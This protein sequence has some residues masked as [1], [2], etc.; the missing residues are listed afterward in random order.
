M[1]ASAATAVH[2]IPS[3][4]G[5]NGAAPEWNLGPA[6]RAGLGKDGEVVD[7]EDPRLR[8]ALPYALE[9]VANLGS[10]FRDA[11]FDLVVGA[12]EV[13]VLARCG[14]PV[15]GGACTDDFLEADVVAADADGP[16]L[17]GFVETVELG[18]V[19]RARV[20]VLRL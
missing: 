10:G 8:R 12:A 20:D 2:S 6:T 1:T 3:W 9:H 7:D 5:C 19:G 16:E 4:F 11:V 17:R 15:G 13:T 18:R 14:R